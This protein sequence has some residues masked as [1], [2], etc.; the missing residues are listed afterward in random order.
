MRFKKLS[1]RNYRGVEASSVE[2]AECGITVVQGPNE[3][4][5]SSLAEA[6]H[7]LYQFKA[8]SMDGKVRKLKPVHRDA[9]PE[10]E[11]EAVSG[12]Y[13]FVY[14][15]KY[16]KSK[17]A[18]VLTVLT[19]KPESLTG[20]SAHDRADKILADTLDKKLWDALI[21]RQ[22][23][24]IG[25]PDLTGKN[26]LMSALDAAAGGGATDAS[27]EDIFERAAGAYRK[28]YTAND[29]EGRELTQARE[30][31]EL[32]H[33]KAA[34]L[35]EQLRDIDAKT[36]K[37]ARLRQQRAQVEA[38]L[39]GKTEKLTEKRVVVQ[40]LAVL[41]AALNEARLRLEAAQAQ[42]QA[43]RA[44]WQVR[45]RL[46]EAAE[47]AR[48]DAAQLAGAP[49]TGGERQALDD[50]LRQGDESVRHT[51][52][53]L[54]EAEAALSRA[55]EDCDQLRDNERLD[56]LRQRS[57]RL[58][59]ARAQ[60]AEAAAELE[61]NR[62]DAA[63]LEAIKQADLAATRLR[64]HWQA[65]APRVTVSGLGEASLLV[66]G[67]PLALS[68]SSE[69]EYAVAG[70]MA[71]ELPG[72]VRIRIDAG[73]ALAAER[74]KL[75]EAEGHLEAL[76]AAAGT[77]DV[78]AAMTAAMRRREA[79]QAL[80]A[81]KLR[82]KTELGGAGD[83]AS[84][85][86]EMEQRLARRRAA[87]GDT[88][89]LPENLD[90]ALALC[91]QAEDAVRSAVAAA[92]TARATLD[93]LRRQ[94]DA[95]LATDSEAR[96]RRD[97]L[98]KSL[99]LAEGE[100]AAARAEAADALL[101]EK[102]AQTDQAAAARL[103]E[104][105]AAE[106]ALAGRNPGREKALLDALEGAL[107]SLQT[108]LHTIDKEQTALATELRLRGEDGVFELLQEARVEEEEAGLALAAI[109]AKAAAARI[110]YETMRAARETA[111]RSYIMPLKE[112]IEELGRW[113]F[114]AS[115]RVELNE[116]NLSIATRSMQ[117]AT[118]PFADLSGG[119]REQLSLIF[120]AACAILVSEREGMPLI[121]DDALGYSDSER[122]ELMG[123]VLAKAAEQCQIIIFTCMP[124]R[125]ASIGNAKV[126]QL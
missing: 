92:D 112:K 86:L 71:F 121:L 116:E 91:S 79:E 32:A 55:R 93:A 102:A 21:V 45:T 47:N 41:D 12:P 118:V 38:D 52:Q 18:T 70:A 122:L 53:L 48:A 62:V 89:P 27:A 99:R 124:E 80:A 125:Y 16:H 97:V 101:E 11:L 66:D 1:I 105:K 74:D 42:N 2:F 37:I 63:A 40:E 34:S 56:E 84:A 64:S 20:D 14:G 35:D 83:P 59:Q 126:I 4:G 87:R 31:L 30:R 33:A 19:P 106:A 44:A 25:I 117:G 39:A 24:M 96:V 100:L 22:G 9:D 36:E 88:V 114:D 51:V 67:M 73:G 46:I 108:R 98:E 123:A 69:K 120:R 65:S 94:R 81:A 103:G 10:I 54:R 57:E 15:K 85:I 5:K 119:A 113:V 13:H 28:Y 76:C 58:A 75:D 8:S 29:R 104:T 82:E 61:R 7:I 110:L 3:V 23:D 115:F 95:A 50:R 17:S 72:T 6:V 78:E 43:A 107:V 49:A 77:A 60:A 26:A 111:R 109:T 68:E 90:A